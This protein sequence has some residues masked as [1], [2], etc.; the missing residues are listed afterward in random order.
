MEAVLPKVQDA[1]HA[2]FQVDPQRITLETVPG[3]VEGWDS[4]GHINLVNAL[5]NEFH[6]S[7]DVDELMAMENVRE[8]V[9]IVQS[10]LTQ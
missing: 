9:R 2:A 1:F 8:I 10:K 7:F 6:T 5:E 3:D 4:M